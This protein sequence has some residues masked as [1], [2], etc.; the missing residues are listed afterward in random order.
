MFNPETDTFEA[1]S[2]AMVVNRKHHVAVTLPDGRVLVFDDDNYYMG[3]VIAERL[4][5]E[6]KPVIL[7]TPKER[8]ASW[9][10]YTYEQARARR[11]L[12]ELEV[13]IVLSHAL[14]AFDGREAT[15]ACT[16]MAR[17]QRVAAD[18]LVLVTARSPNDGLYRALSERLA[19]E[20]PAAPRSLL[21]IGDCDAPAIIAA[22]VHAGHRYAQELD[23]PG[24][25][26]NHPLR[27]EPMMAEEQGI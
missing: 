25:G 14:S 26:P 15:L 22:A 16:F 9:S 13:E 12:L 18:S 20:V 6:G 27:R 2:R 17:E 3:A 1:V 4:R 21:R 8:V 10:G 23:A 11:R 24:E 7:V 5:N 19:A